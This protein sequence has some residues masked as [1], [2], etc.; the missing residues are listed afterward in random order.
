MTVYIMHCLAMKLCTVFCWP[1]AACRV[2]PVVALTIIQV[3]IDMSVKMIRPVIPGS[4]PDEDTAGEPFRAIVTIRSAVVRR[5]L[6]V[7]VRANRRFSNGDRNLRGRV[8]FSSDEK[9]RRCNSQTTPK[10]KMS[11]CFHRLTFRVTNT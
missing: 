10:T 1:L 2:R 9:S 5:R 8:M 6:V 4:C 3:V 11:Q 7:P